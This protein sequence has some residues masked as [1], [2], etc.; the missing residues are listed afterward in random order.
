MK[1]SYMTNAFAPLVGTTAGVTS[2]KDNGYLTDGSEDMLMQ[3]VVDGGYQYFDIFEGNLVRYEDHPEEFEALMKKHNLKLL[4]VYIGC[5][6]IYPDALD[7]ELAKVEQIVKLAKRFGATQ[8]VFGGGSLRASGIRDED[9]PLLAA[10]IDKA[11]DI[12]RKYG[13]TPSYHPHLGSLAETPEQIHK[14]FALTDIGF[15][16]DTAH[17]VAGGADA[18]EII[19]DYRDRVV[20]VHLKDLDT[21]GNFVPLGKGTIP[22]KEII[23]YLKSSGYTGDWCVEIDGYSG[24][25]HEACVTSR[26]YLKEVL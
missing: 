9:Y 8:I 7:D 2:M 12:V 13:L 6:F 10:G 26:N 25:P 17:L 5:H 20:Y 19:K 21:N 11:A 18:L 23:E 4:G 1:L 3:E 14:L 22:L 24:D 15:C 16:P